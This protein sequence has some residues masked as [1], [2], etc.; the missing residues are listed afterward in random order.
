MRA[1]TRKIDKVAAIRATQKATEA[2]M[3]AV[4]SYLKSSKN[5]TSEGAHKI[6]DATLAEYNCESPEGHI[7]AGGA[8]SA[9][10]HEIGKGEI[11]KNVP[12]VIDIY[13][14]SKETKYFSTKTSPS[15]SVPNP[16]P[17]PPKSR[18]LSTKSP[19]K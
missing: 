4:I 8:Q 2:A 5:P 9:E 16:A 10:P 14:R 12:I 3:A 17:P 13:P 19:P 15:S 18:P 7:V 1:N 6:I 11:K